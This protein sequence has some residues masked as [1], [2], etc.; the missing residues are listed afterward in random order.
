VICIVHCERSLIDPDIYAPAAA[1]AASF[2]RAIH[3]TMLCTCTVDPAPLPLLRPQSFDSSSLSMHPSDYVM[4]CFVRYL[5]SYCKLMEH[6]HHIHVHLYAVFAISWLSIVACHHGWIG[7]FDP[8]HAWFDFIC[9]SADSDLLPLREC[10]QLSF[11]PSAFLFHMAAAVTV[12]IC[13]LVL[14]EIASDY[15][16]L[17]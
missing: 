1:I 11:L 8:C 6:G 3:Y 16:H 10:R 9:K 4:P 7:C 2:V 5:S 15:C 12:A 13:M 14:L 17:R